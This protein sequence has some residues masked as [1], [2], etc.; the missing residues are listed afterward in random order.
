[1]AVG[2]TGVLVALLLYTLVG[3]SILPVENFYTR[4]SSYNFLKKTALTRG[5]IGSSKQTRSISGTPVRLVQGS[6]ADSGE[7]QQSN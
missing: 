6:S 7:T 2:G 5:Q 3:K 1:M 4:D